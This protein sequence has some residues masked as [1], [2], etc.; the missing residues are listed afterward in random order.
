MAGLQSFF[1][2]KSWAYMICF[3]NR[4]SDEG[5]GFRASGRIARHLA[6][7]VIHRIGGSFAPSA[8][9]RGLSLPVA[10]GSA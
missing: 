6:H 5:Q 10:A 7:N 3:E 9:A 8:G 2:Y 4:H 1:L